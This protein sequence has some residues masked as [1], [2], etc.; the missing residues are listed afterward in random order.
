M[1]LVAM[2]RPRFDDE[3][4][5]TFSGKIGVFPFVTIQSAQRTSRNREAGTMEMKPITSVKRDDIR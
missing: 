1:M 2:A 3:G 5:K 4:I